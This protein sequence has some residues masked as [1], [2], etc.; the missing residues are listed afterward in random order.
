MRIIA[1]F[2]NKDQVGFLVDTLR[3]KGFDRKDMIIS[4]LESELEYGS[5]QEATDKG[6]SLIKTE[7][8][9]LNRIES[10]AAGINGLEG[11]TG[12]VVAVDTPRHEIDR[13]RLFMEQ[14]GAVQIIQE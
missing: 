11:K 1:R 8:E 14:A 5:L 3:N 12:I 2:A 6:V 13:V 9:S 4:D 7:S 10:F